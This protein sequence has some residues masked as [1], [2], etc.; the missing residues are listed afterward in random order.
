M[1]YLRKILERASRGKI[2][3]RSL[4]VGGY[5]VPIFVSPDAQLKYWKPGDQF[6]RDL[7][8]LAE[9][10]IK[11]TDV[12]WDI[13]ANIGVFTF[14]VNSI[15]KEGEVVAVEADTFLVGLL[16]RTA[17][18]AFHANSKI[19]VL[20]AAV[21]NENG[22]ATFTV[23]QRGRAS[24]S[25]EA[26][27]E[28][29][30]AGGVREFQYVPTVSLDA[31]LNYFTPPD[32]VKVDVEGAELLVIDGANKLITDYK[33]KFYVEVWQQHSKE[34]FERFRAAG[35]TAYDPTGSVLR[36]GCAFNTLFLP[37]KA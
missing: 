15:L 9:Q 36:D 14:A 6:D 29:S 23:A 8:Q 31:M 16:R 25:L 11:P 17:L 24:N 35:Y 5:Q 7:I 28:N 10:Q 22:I 33:P 4:T 18:L 37:E 20:P 21:S 19:S 30:Q 13:G 32:F 12:V 26:V 27:A 3:R 2:L 1:N 34:I